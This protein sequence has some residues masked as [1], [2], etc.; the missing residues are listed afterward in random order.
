MNIFI[1]TCHYQKYTYLLDT[2]QKPQG[3]DYEFHHKRPH[4]PKCK[5][6]VSTACFMHCALC[7]KVCRR[8]V[9]ILLHCDGSNCLVNS[10]EEKAKW[11]YNRNCVL[12]G[13]WSSIYHMVTYAFGYLFDMHF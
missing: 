2:K 1:I 11:I 12:N 9:D 13:L 10:C 8:C 4:H 7:L 5:N 3:S 6:V